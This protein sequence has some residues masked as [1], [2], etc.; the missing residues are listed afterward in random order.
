[1]E[2]LSI[3]EQIKTLQEKQK[4]LIYIQNKKAWENWHKETVEFLNSIIGKTF[5]SKTGQNDFI[6]FKIISY[7]KSNWLGNSDY[8]GFYNDLCAWCNQPHLF[9]KM[10]F[11][12]FMQKRTKN[13]N[14]IDTNIKLYNG[15]DID[16]K[17]KW[18]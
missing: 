7:E 14:R 6:I 8:K 17:I 5:I 12:E 10:T 4:E 13:V 16:E 9:K 11:E 18:W 2:N 3:E 1:M 15:M